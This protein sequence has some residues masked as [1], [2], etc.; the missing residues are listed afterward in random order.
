M[1]DGGTTANVTVAKNSIFIMSGGVLIAGEGRTAGSLTVV[2]DARA[3]WSGGIILGAEFEESLLG[4]IGA[5]GDGALIQILGSGF[6]VDGE[7]VPGGYIE[8]DSGTLTGTLDSGD[9]IEVLFA[10]DGG[11]DR[12]NVL[13]SGLIWLPEPNPSLLAFAAAAALGLL[14][15]RRVQF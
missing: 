10:H 13:N 11:R 9:P 6:A 7:A 14:A 8:A 3:E 2:D 5:K 15:P 1:V 4:N 12:Y